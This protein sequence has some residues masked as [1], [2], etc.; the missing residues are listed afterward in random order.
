MTTSE[1][2]AK[3]DARKCGA[4]WKAKCPAHTDRHPSL[5]ITEGEDGGIRLKCFSAGC[6]TEAIV[7]AV[8]LTMADLFA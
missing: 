6:T 7:A 8:G 1:L 3:F 4:G 5:S 2:A